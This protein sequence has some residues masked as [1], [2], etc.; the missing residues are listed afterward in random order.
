MRAVSSAKFKLVSKPTTTTTTRNH[1]FRARYAFASLKRLLAF[2]RK[3]K[4]IYRLIADLLEKMTPG[5]KVGHRAFAAVVRGNDD[6]NEA[7]PRCT[8]PRLQRFSPGSPRGA[9][10]EGKKKGR[11]PDGSGPQRDR[12]P[13]TYAVRGRGIWPAA[14]GEPT[15]F[16]GPVEQQEPPA[17]C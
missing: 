15:K 1:L 10:A 14:P 3:A 9:G 11:L 8:P 17:P 12:T 5:G 2:N 13:Q 7:P 6:G 4:G 16:A